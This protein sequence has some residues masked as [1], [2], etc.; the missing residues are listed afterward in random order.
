MRFNFVRLPSA[1][2]LAFPNR[3]SILAPFIPIR[4]INFNDRDKTLYLK[5]LIDSGADV[6]IFPKSVGDAISLNIENEKILKI[7]GIGG[8]QIDTYLHKIIFEVGGWKLPSFACFAS[9]ETTFPI[10]GRDGFFSL[11]EIKLNYSKEIIELK[12]RVDPIQA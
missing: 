4:I 11:F 8:Q 7:K 2:S 6:S 12:P 3:Y 1:P 5:A 10:L 9:V